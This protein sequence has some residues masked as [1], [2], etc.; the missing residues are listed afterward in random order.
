MKFTLSWL[1]DYLE[2]N[3]SVQEISDTL[4][5]IGLEVE[6]IIDN[7]KALEPFI[8]GEV[9]E[10][11]KHPDADKLHLLKVSKGAGDILQVV[12]GAPNVKKRIE[13]RFSFRR[14]YYSGKR[15]AFEKRE[16]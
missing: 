6:D 16:N 12:C 4:T 14:R 9:I 10:C 5:M 13:R 15:G 11:G 3:A 8:V 2:T 1:K 7:S